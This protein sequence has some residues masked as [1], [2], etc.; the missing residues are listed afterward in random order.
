VRS[1]RFRSFTKRGAALG[2]LA[3]LGGGAA[4]LLVAA[5]IAVVLVLVF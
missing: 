4:L 2:V 3:V 5:V 1:D